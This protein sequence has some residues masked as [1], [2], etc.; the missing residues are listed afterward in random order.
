M[1]ARSFLLGV[2]VVLVFAGVVVL[3][4]NSVYEEFH[5]FSVNSEKNLT[6]ISRSGLDAECN[7]EVSLRLCRING[8]Y[9]IG[10]KVDGGPYLVV[11]VNRT[12]LRD[13]LQSIEWEGLEEVECP[14][15]VNT[16][17]EPIG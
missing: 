8:I 9:Q 3:V 12:V 7:P 16:L 2:S 5:C 15:N 1:E 13:T 14:G 6:T 17:K 11:A 4:M 10:K